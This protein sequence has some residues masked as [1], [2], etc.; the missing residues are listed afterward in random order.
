MNADYGMIFNIQKFSINDGPGIRTVVFFKGCPLKCTWC[1]NPESQ[2]PRLQILWDAKKC[3]HCE[4]CVRSCP[5]QAVTAVDGKISVDHKKC[6]GAG[7]CSERGICI[8]KCP[9]HALKPEGQR[10]TV[11]EILNV[12]MQDLPFY[13]ESGG[14]VTLSG[15]EATMQPEFAIELLRALKSK[16]IHTAIETTGFA[17]PAIFRRIV[18]YVDLLLFDIKHWDETRHRDKTG[19]SNAPI[20]LNMKF[21]IDAGKDVL[22]RLPVIPHYNDSIDDAKGFV[23]RLRE[24]GATKVQ[25][26]PFHQFGENKYSMLGRDYE[27]SHVKALHPEDLTA[28]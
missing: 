28:F 12:V 17:S 2:E 6:S 15:G 4:T 19:V 25:L 22:P 1:A 26:L 3:L 23:R 18:E 11:D 7:V 13:E 21:A 27:F 9:A 24:V 20:L 10:K 14:G 5:T 8:E 16:N